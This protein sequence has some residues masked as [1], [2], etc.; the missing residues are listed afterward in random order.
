PGRQFQRNIEHLN[1]VLG[2]L[3]HKQIQSFTHQCEINSPKG[4]RKFSYPV[5]LKM[6][7]EAI[8]RQPKHRNVRNSGPLSV[9]GSSLLKLPSGE[10]GP[11]RWRGPTLLA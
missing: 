1:F 5:E 4:Q 9:I 3:R 2:W 10:L 6:T 11:S 7:E 8:F